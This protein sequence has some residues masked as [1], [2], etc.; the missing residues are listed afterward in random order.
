MQLVIRKYGNLLDVSP[1]GRAPTPPHVVDALVPIA[2]YIYKRHLRGADAY[3]P[4]TGQRQ[5]MQLEDRRLWTMSTDG[6]FTC[7][8]GYL[9]RIVK[10]LSQQG[11]TVHYVDISPPPARPNRYTPCWENVYRHIKFRAKQEECLQSIVNSYGGVVHAVTGFGKTTMMGATALLFPYAKVDIVVRQVDIAE[12]IVRNLTRLLPC[13]GQVGGG[14]RRRERVTVYT[15]D[16][17]HLSEGD[18]DFLFGDEAHQLAAP[19]YAEPLAQ[20]YRFSRN[21]CFSATPYGRVDGAS[22]RL[23]SLFGPTIFQLLYPEAVALGLVVP[24]RV[25]WV[26]MELDHNPAAGKTDD[27]AKKRWGIWRNR[28][29]NAKFAEFVRQSYR[30]DQQVLVLVESLEHAVNFLQDMPEAFLAYGNMK[31]E[32]FHGYVR[33][34]LLPPDFPEMTS[35]RRTGLREAFERGDLKRAIATDVWS[36]GV[37]FEQLSAVVRADDR[38]NEILDSQGPGRASRIYTDANGVSKECGEVVDGIDYWDKRFFKKSQERYGNYK[39]L[40]WEQ[41][42]PLARR[43][44]SRLSAGSATQR[45][46]RGA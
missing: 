14:K 5:H 34:G 15:A 43:P 27:V 32:D 3:D 6:K 28:A 46:R 7:G 9:S 17:L 23:E 35:D 41:D 13:V 30:P 18:A 29:R 36:T 39:L 24:I 10:T 40:E 8:F 11:H 1:D 16:S 42:W 38:S 4:A 25:H 22:A 44:S 33:A 2:T 37:D 31:R 20:L 12:R 45:R 19:S 21:Y 26:P